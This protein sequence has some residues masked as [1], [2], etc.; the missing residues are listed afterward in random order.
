MRI[1]IACLICLLAAVPGFAEETVLAEIDELEPGQ[2]ELRAFELDQEQEVEIDAVGLQAHRNFDEL[3]AAWILDAESRGVVWEMG[4]A[5]PTRRRKEL[6]EYAD[7]VHLR[8]GIYEVYYATYPGRD[9]HAGQW[10]EE[11]ARTVVEALLGWD[12]YEDLT[13]DLQLTVRGAGR[14]W[15]SQETDRFHQELREEALISLAG[16]HDE[17]AEH[18]GFVLEREMELEIYALGE[19]TRDGGYDY[20]W[21]LDTKTR[22]QVWSFDYRD[23][24]RAGGAVK[25]RVV[26][27]ELS[28]PAGSYAAFFVTDGSHS[29]EQWNVLPPH[30]PVFWGLTLWA[31]H[32]SQKQWAQ[33]AE[34]RHL[35]EDRV[36]A[37]LTGLGDDEYLSQGMTLEQPMDVRIYAIG[38]GGRRGMSDYGWLADARSRET[39]WEMS[40]DRTTHAGGSQKNR[41]VDEI[42]HLEPGS[43]LLSFVT[44][45]SH[46]YRDWN[47]DPP[48]YPQRWGITLFSAE[49]H[50]DPSAVSEYRAE[51]DP[52][53]LAR[54]GRMR[55]DR[56]ERQEFSLDRDAEVLIYAL[57][58]GT[59]GRMY[60][61]GWIEDSRSGRTVWEMDYRSTERAGGAEKNR[62]YRG[63]IPLSAG[64]YTLYYETDDSHSFEDWNAAPPHDPEG[65]GIQVLVVD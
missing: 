48:S 41:L 24:D 33:R 15:S 25:N 45:G 3:T 18:Q 2:L 56:R 65:W 30:D 50:F 59:D 42:L 21:I 16:L 64:E 13:A 22:E 31:R 58:E 26:R 7:T 32:P 51:E 62:L 53:I 49:E 17:L 11:A 37:E 19:L 46:A 23:S 20:G 63:K 61:Y 34:Y 52:A 27:T 8:A 4:E 5:R 57:G 38:E 47:A 10:W 12:D 14:A 9:H 54:I 40:Y 29:P 44:D 60:D 1:C 55:D 43:Y 36:I 35:P 39:V 28:L 6:R